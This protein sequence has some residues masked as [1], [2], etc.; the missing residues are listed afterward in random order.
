MRTD[1]PGLLEP[2]DVGLGHAKQLQP[3]APARLGGPGRLEPGLGGAQGDL[4]LLHFRPRN[5]LG[6]G[7]LLAG[8]KILL[9]NLERR[10]GSGQLRQL[11]EMIVL[12]RSKLGA[13]DDEQQI[14]R[15]NRV[16]DTLGQA[17]HAAT[18]QRANVSQGVLVVSQPRR[19]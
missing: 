6:V 9:R 17:R 1:R 10:R 11:A 13:V 2:R 5:R 4:P 16:A 15:G 14:G 3:V 18:H 8:L 7:K 12:R 19:G